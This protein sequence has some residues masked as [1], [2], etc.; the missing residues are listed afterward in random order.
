[1]IP[2]KNKSDIIGRDQAVAETETPYDTTKKTGKIAASLITGL[3]FPIGYYLIL[4][5]I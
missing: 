3:I 5:D 1:M 2:D 4:N